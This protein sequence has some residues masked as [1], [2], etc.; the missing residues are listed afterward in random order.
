MLLLVLSKL[1][2]SFLQFNALKLFITANAGAG[3]GLATPL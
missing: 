1:S 3:L 2:D